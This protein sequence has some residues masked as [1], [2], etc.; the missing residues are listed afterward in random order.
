MIVK[1]V[2]KTMYTVD[3]D[4]SPRDWYFDGL[5]EVSFYRGGS[6]VSS[7]NVEIMSEYDEF[8]REKATFTTIIGQRNG[9][10]FVIVTDQDTYLMNDEGK[11]LAAY[12]V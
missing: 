2:D 10:K 8:H 12:K 5:L 1:V 9:Q 11:T 3:K 4:P 6:L 7:C